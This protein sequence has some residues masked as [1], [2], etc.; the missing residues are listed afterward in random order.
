MKRML[1]AVHEAELVSR[2]GRVTEITGLVTIADGPD[3]FLGELCEI[4]T[5]E[6]KKPLAAEVVGLK[7]NRVLLMPYGDVRGIRL[8]SEV[9][10]TGRDVDAPVGQALLG[11][12]VDAFC[13]PLDNGPNLALKQRYPL[14]A[15]PINPLKRQRIR[16]PLETGVRSIDGLLTVGKGQRVGIFAGSGVGKSTLLGMI[17]RNMQADVNVIALIGERGREVKDFIDDCLGEEGLRK[18]V[19]I[20][21]TSDQPALIRAHA[22]FAATSIAEYFRDQGLDVVLTMDSITRF[23]TAQREIGLAVGEPPTARGYTPSVFSVLPKLLE[24]GGATDKGSI[25]AFYTVLVE[26]DELNEP[27]SDHVRAI[28][29]GHVVLSRKIANRGH[30]PAVDVL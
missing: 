2:L 8:G 13:R 26:G 7:N 14:Y 23:A 17:A 19:V 12:V 3:V 4:W 25:T 28:L 20:V 10:A 22:A 6:D 29:D 16:E 30:F 5:G 15:D 24:R 11:R 18:S 9:A 21:A 27:I 1:Q